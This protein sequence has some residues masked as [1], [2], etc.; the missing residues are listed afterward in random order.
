MLGLGWVGLGWGGGVANGRTTVRE[1]EGQGE[2]FKLLPSVP[3]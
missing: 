3:F 1:I 2:F